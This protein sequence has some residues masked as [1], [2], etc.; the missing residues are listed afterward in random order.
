MQTIRLFKEYNH[1][2]DTYK[3]LFNKLDK[4]DKEEVKELIGD[5]ISE[6]EDYHLGDWPRHSDGVI[7]SLDFGE[8]TI[9][10]IFKA[11][12]IISADLYYE[13]I[14]WLIRVNID[15]IV[16]EEIRTKVKTQINLKD[17]I[18]V[19]H[20]IRHHANYDFAGDDNIYYINTDE[21]KLDLNDAAT[22][23][24]LLNTKDKSGFG[25]ENTDKKFID[26]I[27][28]NELLKTKL[29]KFIQLWEYVIK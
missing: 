22:I 2:L 7:T 25:R 21:G 17:E 28:E 11:C 3:S 5:V 18:I 1:D 14:Y 20:T 12:Q 13:I 29:N 27:N 15:S 9:E 16:N 10:D 19:K 8:Q 23:L 6:V 24:I 26:L 4:K